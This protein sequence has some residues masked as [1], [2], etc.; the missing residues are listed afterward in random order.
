[1]E[2]RFILLVARIFQRSIHPIARNCPSIQ[3]IQ[4][5]DAAKDN[6]NPLRR[7]LLG[8]LMTPKSTILSSNLYHTPQSKIVAV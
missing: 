7:K 4:E 5:I 1:M 2:A 8:L 6:K 3:V